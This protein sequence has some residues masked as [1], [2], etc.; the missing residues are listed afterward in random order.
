MTSLAQSQPS[1]RLVLVALNKV[2]ARRA[3][4]QR[5]YQVELARD[6]CLDVVRQPVRIA[7]GKDLASRHRGGAAGRPYLLDI[8][9]VV[10]IDDAGHVKV[11]L[12]VT[13]AKGD[14]SQ[15]A[16]DVVVAFLDGVEV[17]D[18]V[19]GEDDL[20]SPLVV[21]GDAL[22]VGQAGVGGEVDGAGEL[23]QGPEGDGGGAG[24]GGRGDKGQG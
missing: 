7:A 15:H 9:D 20:G 22:D 16:G 5:G 21:D 6:F 1:R 3:G 2:H 23:I 11:R 24:G 17:A 8:V 4:A 10:G 19:R 12:V 18:P 13:A 14:F